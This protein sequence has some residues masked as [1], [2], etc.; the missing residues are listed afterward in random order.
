VGCTRREWLVVTAAA[1]AGSTV[2]ARRGDAV[3]LQGE[4]GAP[5]QLREMPPSIARIADVTIDERVEPALVF[6]PR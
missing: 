6:I 1:A 3:G 2:I 5:A 4:R